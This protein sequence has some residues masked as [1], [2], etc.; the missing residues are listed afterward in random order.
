MFGSR[1]SDEEA[2]GPELP[3]LLADAFAIGTPLLR[4]LA[5]I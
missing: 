2:L 1:L 5:P 4:Y 3:E